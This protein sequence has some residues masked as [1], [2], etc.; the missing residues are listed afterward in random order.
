MLKVVLSWHIYPYELLDMQKGV[1]C[2]D[3]QTCILQAMPKARE[4]A[5]ADGSVALY[6]DG[7]LVGFR[8]KRIYTVEEAALVSKDTGN[9]IKLRY[10]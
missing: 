8:G 5:Q 9:T 6:R 3:R 1:G 10:K 2:S 4:V 7:K